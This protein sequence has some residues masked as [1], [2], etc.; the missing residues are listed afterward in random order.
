M[1]TK[2]EAKRIWGK[3]KPGSGYKNFDSWYVDVVEKQ[4]ARAQLKSEIVAINN[5]ATMTVY[6]R[7]SRARAI[8]ART[9]AHRYRLPTSSKNAGYYGEYR[10]HISGPV[11]ETTIYKGRYKG[12]KSI[13][14]NTG[15]TIDDTRRLVYTT[16][17]GR[18]GRTDCIIPADVRFTRCN[19]ARMLLI[20]GTFLA[21][22]APEI[23]VGYFRLI[24]HDGTYSETLAYRAETGE[25]E[26]GKT[27]SLIKWE[28][29]RKAIIA[30]RQKAEELKMA[31]QYR[32][33][34]LI[35][36]LV[37]Q[38][39]FPVTF[40]DARNAGFCQPGVAGWVEQYFQPGRESAPYSAVRALIDTDSRVRRVLE[41]AVIREL[42]AV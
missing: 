18:K 5:A 37:R 25:V 31:K 42:K 29:R 33:A 16:G 12:Y 20:P 36:R 24:K 32:K 26:H 7:Y 39:G 1:D 34:R 8:V 2:S 21:V 11:T 40:Q 10:G 19:G 41:S 30:A 6:A 28:L 9:L 4:K 23:G 3:A 14:H 13:A 38:A 22:Q 27:P 15:A 17:R 35:V